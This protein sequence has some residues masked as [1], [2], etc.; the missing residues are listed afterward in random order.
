MTTLSFKKLWS[1]YPD[2]APCNEH[3]SNQCAIKVGSALAQNGVDTTT[4]V[5]VQRQT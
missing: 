5:T 2:E 4:L 3:F 1:A